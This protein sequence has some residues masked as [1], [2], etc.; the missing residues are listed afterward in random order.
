MKIKCIKTKLTNK[1]FE[2]SKMTGGDPD[3]NSNIILDEEYEVY[4]ISIPNFGMTLFLIETSIVCG[5]NTQTEGGLLL[6]VPAVL[7]DIV[8]VSF[9]T[10]WFGFFNSYGKGGEE[11]RWCFQAKEFIEDIY[12]IQKYAD[13]DLQCIAAFQDLKKRLTV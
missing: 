13:Q 12:F 11:N 5:V 10:E 1:E 7:F 2:Y 8:D 6:Y 9:K 4:G 3:F